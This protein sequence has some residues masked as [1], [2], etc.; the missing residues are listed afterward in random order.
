MAISTRTR[1]EIFKRDGFRCVY[2]G[3]APTETPLHADHVIPVAEGG[4]DVPENLVTACAECNLGKSAVPL[5]KVRYAKAQLDPRAAKEH[6]KQIREYLAA[7]KE[8]V[9]ARDSVL[10]TLELHWCSEFQS[11]DTIP[12]DLRKILRGAISDLTVEE[13]T[14]AISIAARYVPTKGLTTQIKYLCGVLRKKRRRLTYS[15]DLLRA[16]ES[17]ERA[18]FRNFRVQ[19][20]DGKKHV[21]WDGPAL[22]P[23]IAA[24][25][26]E[27]LEEFIEI[28]EAA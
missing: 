21:I 27:H 6:A 4:T 5:D 13:V 7:Q 11:G 25:L 23:S 9:D 28:L 16:V 24:D 12:R 19:V 20:R 15:P 8:V 26:T 3:A 17:A 2:C 10:D 14:E 22:P 1:F 18:G